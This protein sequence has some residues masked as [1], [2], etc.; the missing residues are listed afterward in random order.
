MNILVVGA[1]SAIAEATARLWAAR[2]DALYLAARRETLLEASAADL[3]LRGA[4][5]VA[6]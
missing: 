2:G 1:T 4:K 6:F 3:R 5:T